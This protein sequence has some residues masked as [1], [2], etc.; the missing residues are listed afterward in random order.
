[1]RSDGRTR[2]AQQPYHARLRALFA[3]LLDEAHLR[4]D[5]QAV[6]P[7]FGD[8]V[9]VEIDLPSLRRFDEPVVPAGYEFRDAAAALGGVRLDLSAQIAL[10]ILDLPH[11]GVESVADRDQHMLLLGRVVVRLA[12]DHVVVPGHRDADVDL[13]PPAAPVARLRPVDDHPATRDA[14]AELLEPARLFLDLVANRFGRFAAVIGDLDRGLHGVA[15]SQWFA[16]SAGLDVDIVDHVGHARRFPGGLSRRAA[17]CPG[18]NLTAENDGSLLERD[19]EEVRLQ[20]CLAPER[21]LDPRLDVGR[22]GR[23]PQ[24]DR[25]RHADDAREPLDVR[26]RDF[27]LARRPDLPRQSDPAALDL[28]FDSDALQARIPGEEPRAARRSFF[29]QSAA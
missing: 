12:Y 27:A 1:M 17:L 2:F 22:R 13:E 15:L 16:L 25:V 4:A 19:V 10:D 21:L 20:Q 18:M 5:A 14:R 26:Q 11:R 28:H 23:A 9:A 29:S 24:G 7:A 6:E 3:R 8:G